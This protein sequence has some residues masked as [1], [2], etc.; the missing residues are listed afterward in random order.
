MEK[1]LAHISEDGTR[2]QTVYEHLSGTARLAGAFAAPFGAKEEAEYA[3]WLHDIGKYSAAFQQRL[4]GGAA[5]DHS[6]AGA[7][8][9]MKGCTPHVQAAFAV[10][11]HHTGLPDGGNKRAADSA[12]G[13]LFGRLKKPVEP[14]DGWR[15]VTLPQS[16]PPDWANRDPLD[17]AFFTRM[18]YSC[19]VDADFIDTETFMNGQA[20]PRGNSTALSF[21]LEKVR[22]KAAGYLAAQSTLPVSSQRNAVLRACMEKGAHGAPGLYTLTV[23]TGGGKTFASLAFA[24]E[25]AAAQNMKR[26]I[27][28]I[29]Y[30]SIIDQTA[31]VFADLLGAEN[32]LADYSCA[33]YK[34]LEQE[35]LTPAQYRQLLASENWDAPVVVTTAVQFFESLY[36]NRSSRCRKL[37]NIANSVIIFDEAQTLP[38]SYLLPCVSAIA[39]LVRHYHATA[40]LCTATQPALEPYF[41]QFAPELPLQEIVPDTATLY[42]TLRRT[43]L[44]DAGEL[45][46]EALTSQLCALPQVLCVSEPAQNGAGSVRC[47]ACRGQ[48]LPDHAIVRRRPPPPAGRDPAAAAGKPALPG[49]VHLA[50]RSRCGRGFPRRIPGAVRAGLP[51]ADRR[52]L[53]PGRTPQRGREPGI[54]FYAGRLRRTADAAPE[55]TRHA[56]RSRLRRSA[57]QPRGG[58]SLF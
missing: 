27:Y 32:V 6:T 57:G 15:E 8:E 43:T 34:S 44:C 40:V 51:F 46:L 17:F 30:M 1:A 33:D 19:L 28:V 3:A 49:S 13:T 18:L 29:P 36:A 47:L 53:Q 9:A 20:A 50:D 35:K 2:T 45:T 41:R 56:V 37:H 21:L 14:Y 26:V 55:R 31:A 25:Q 12:D 10:A 54:P 11:G 42:T 16:A 48:L 7:Q 52:T 39:Q 24:L 38:T 22:T 5:T 58:Q 4:A 23:P